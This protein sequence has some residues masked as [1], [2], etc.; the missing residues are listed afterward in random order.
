[1]DRVSCL[2]FLLYRME[3]EE[4][5]EAALQLVSGD[6]SIG[7]LKTNQHLLLYIEAAEAKLKKKAF[8][9]NEVY[10]FVEENLYA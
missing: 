5:K 7:E 4:I 9:K 1:M 10:Q 6:I 2:A 3:H 8:N